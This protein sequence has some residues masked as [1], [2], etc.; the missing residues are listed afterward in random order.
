MA[1]MESYSVFVVIFPY[2]LFLG[3]ALN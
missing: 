1:E 2:F 3:R